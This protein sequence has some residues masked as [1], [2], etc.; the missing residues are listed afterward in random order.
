MASFTDLIAQHICMQRDELLASLSSNPNSEREQ[1]LATGVKRYWHAFAPENLAERDQARLRVGAVDGSQAIR[2]LNIGADWIVAQA[3]L[4]GPDGLREAAGETRIVRGDVGSPRVD[5]YASLLMRSLE[6]R[7]ALEFA[8]HKQGN[9]LLIDGSLYSDLPYLLYNLDLAIGGYENLPRKVLANYLDLFEFCQQAHILL[10][11]ISKSTRSTVFGKTL[12]E[13]NDPIGDLPS[14]GE[15]LYRWTE[16]CGLTSPVLLGSASFGQNIASRAGFFPLND[17]F[18]GASIPD[19]NPPNDRYLLERLQ[20]APAIGTFYARLAPGDD[21]LRIDALASAFGHSQLHLLDFEHELIEHE[22]ALPIVGH[23]LDQY[24]GFSVYNA[25]LYVVDREVRLH[26]ET[27]DH[28]Y[29]PILRSQLGS[30]IQ[31]DR[32]TRRFFH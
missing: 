16:G 4:I 23:L 11:G 1:G 6:L 15:L 22:A 31:Y 17:A 13:E 30:H 29:L 24:G 26:A 5:R 7:L 32:S 28:V 27:V 9:M 12:L 21:V 20:V 10:L 14:D 8:R 25:A 19:T 3:L 18:P 2:S